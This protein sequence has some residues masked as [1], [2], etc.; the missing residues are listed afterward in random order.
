[1][2]LHDGNKQDEGLSE[3]PMKRLLMANEHDL[4]RIE[5]FLFKN[6]AQKEA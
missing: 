5:G 1:M 2:I 4:K 6:V 3:K